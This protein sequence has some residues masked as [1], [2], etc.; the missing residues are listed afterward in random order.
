MVY[1]IWKDRDIEK[2]M[3]KDIR[4]WKNIYKKSSNL[5]KSFTGSFSHFVTASVAVNVL[6]TETVLEWKEAFKTLPDFRKSELSLFSLL[7]EKVSVCMGHL[8]YWENCRKL[9]PNLGIQTFDVYEAVTFLVLLYQ[10]K[11]ISICKSC[12][13]TWVNYYTRGRFKSR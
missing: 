1:N 13:E 6:V 2:D 3:Q 10:D 4:H 12:L 9:P 7:L 11:I 8:F 5:A